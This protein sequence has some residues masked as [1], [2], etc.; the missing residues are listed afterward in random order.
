MGILFYVFLSLF[1]AAGNE[2]MNGDNSV[3][4][5][6]ITNNLEIRDE[7]QNTRKTW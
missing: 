4:A 7:P 2:I 1:F 6:T 3:A 5:P